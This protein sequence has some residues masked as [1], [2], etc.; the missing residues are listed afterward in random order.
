MFFSEIVSLSSF[1]SFFSFLYIIIIIL[2]IIIITSH[3]SLVFFFFLLSCFS[4]I[5]WNE[6][7]ILIRRWSELVVSFR[8]RSFFVSYSDV[9]DPCR[10]CGNVHW[11]N[12]FLQK[13][14]ITI[15]KLRVCLHDICFTL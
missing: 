7:H 5:C 9:C 10:D 13:S 1:L 11:L 14:V 4:V 8:A 3:F 2:I 6:H 15:V 12:V